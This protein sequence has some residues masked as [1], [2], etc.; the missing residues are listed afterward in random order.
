M[1]F[2]GQIQ[3]LIDRVKPKHAIALRPMIKVQSR[4]LNS[5]T[6]PITDPCHSQSDAFAAI[7]VSITTMQQ[8]A[9]FNDEK[10]SRI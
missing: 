6:S 9:T 5:S 3:Q 7:E 10:D 8:T 4:E 2:D 1:V